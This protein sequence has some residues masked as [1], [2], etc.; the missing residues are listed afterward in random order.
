MKTICTGKEFRIY[1]DHLKVYDMLPTGSYIVRFNPMQGFYLEE[2]A[3]IEICENKIYGVHTAKVEKCLKAFVKSN[4]NFGVIL[5]GAKGIGKTLFAKLLSRT[6]IERGYPLI[7]IDKFVPGI[8]S[9][10]EEIE[11]EVVVLFDE[12]DKTFG[13]IRAGDNEAS[14]QAT[15][16]TLFDGVSVGKKL[17]IVTCNKLQNL[18][19]YLIN[20]PGRFHYHFR[21][22]CPD[23][24]EVKEYLQDKI[25]EEYWSEIQKVV[26]FSR[27]VNLNYDCLRAIALELQNGTTFDEAIKDLNI[28][29]LEAMPYRLILSFTDGSKMTN[30]CIN[31]NMF[32]E[33]EDKIFCCV[34]DDSGKASVGIEFCPLDAEY[35]IL[36]GGS[37]IRGEKISISYDDDRFSDDGFSNN[38][39]SDNRKTLKTLVPDYL[40]IS[41]IG[42]RNIHYTV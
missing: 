31:I 42:E 15:L 7:V 40:I 8:V 10:I 39:F 6:A 4:R 11:Q 12:F 26:V 34:H 23:G 38:G 41:R 17:F 36:K 29:N 9:F 37:V 16:L 32:C 5:S 25:N 21:F 19:D 22:E 35:D 24:D 30:R 1:S 3:D 14:P 28:V 20:R 18:N 13:S 33:T 27:K 2:Y